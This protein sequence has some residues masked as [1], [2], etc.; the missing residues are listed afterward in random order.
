VGL[1]H[2]LGIIVKIG[3]SFS[4]YFCFSCP[5]VGDV[6][7]GNL[8][9]FELNEERTEL[10]LDGTLENKAADDDE[11]L[12]EVIFGRNLGGISD[13]EDGPDGYL[14]TV[15]IGLGK[16]FRIVPEGQ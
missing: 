15:S 12:D 14:Y 11:G 7:R 10:I 13:L 3:Y 16:I 8:Y 9:N 5:I 4:F 2:C 1:C 6:H